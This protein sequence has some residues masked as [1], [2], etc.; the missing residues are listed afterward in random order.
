VKLVFEI[1]VIV[2][3]SFLKTVKIVGALLRVYC[4]NFVTMY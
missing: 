1:S 2:M 4:E 3:H